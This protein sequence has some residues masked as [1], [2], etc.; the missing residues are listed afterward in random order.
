MHHL[1]IVCEA[2]RALSSE[3]KAQQTQV[4]WEKVAGM[5][6]ILIHEYFGIDTDIVWAVVEKELPSLKKAIEK[7]LEQPKPQKET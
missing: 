5:R 1:Q 2:A 6:N 3:S 7:M 4:P